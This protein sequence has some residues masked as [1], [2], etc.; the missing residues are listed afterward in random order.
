MTSMSTS[1]GRTI[2]AKDMI[3]RRSCALTRSSLSGA[4]FSTYYPTA[5]T[6][7]LTAKFTLATLIAGIDMATEPGCAASFDRAHDTSFAATKMTG[8]LLPVGATVL[9]KDVG[10]FESRSQPTIIPAASPPVAIGQA[11]LPWSGSCR[12]KPACNV[13]CSTGVH[14]RAVLG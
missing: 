1:G 4:S 6:V 14:D 12:W 13:P 10:N 9:P 3:A 11:G 8:V 2:D 5:F 7:C